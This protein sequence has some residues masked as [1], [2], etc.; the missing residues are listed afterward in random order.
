MLNRDL[1]HKNP[2]KMS[3]FAPDEEDNFVPL[4]TK[5]H[6]FFGSG[7]SLSRK[8]SFRGD[9]LDDT[10]FRPLAKVRTTL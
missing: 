5:S 1:K 6:S 4:T 8:K 10:Q 7:P 2:A 3:S 9:Q